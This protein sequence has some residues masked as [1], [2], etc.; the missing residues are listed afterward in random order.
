MNKR[1]RVPGPKRV[2]LQPGQTV[3]FSIIAVDTTG[4]PMS[5]VQRI[6]VSAAPEVDLQQRVREMLTRSRKTLNRRKK[7][8]G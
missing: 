8:S 5:Q 3:E 2:I 7:S 1:K 4:K 6:I